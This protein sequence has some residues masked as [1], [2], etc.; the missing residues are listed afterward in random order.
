M[1]TGRLPTCQNKVGLPHSRHF[2]NLIAAIRSNATAPNNCHQ[3]NFYLTNNYLHQSS[4]YLST[5]NKV[6]NIHKNSED[7]LKSNFLF[8]IS[9]E[10]SHWL[11]SAGREICILTCDWLK[12]LRL[13]LPCTLWKYADRPA[14]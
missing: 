7:C 10:N 1:D 5:N 4:I 12:D 14:G 8:T 9:N 2:N 3:S 11:W 6:A 13:Q